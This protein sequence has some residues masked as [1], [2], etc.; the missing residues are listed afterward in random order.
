LILGILLFGLALVTALLAIFQF[1]GLLFITLLGVAYMWAAFAFV[2]YRSLRRD[3]LLQVLATA[4]ETG[5]PLAAA[6]RAYLLDRPH[7]PLHEFWV[8][9]LLFFLLPGYYWLWHKNHSYDRKVDR[10]AMLLE[11]GAPLSHALRE[12]PG[13]ASR[14]TMLAAAVG[15]ATNRLASSL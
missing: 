9:T 10:L 14:E 8:A 7:G 12:T 11:G 4:A 15:E 1:E 2:R 13:V 5:A 6:L 3:E